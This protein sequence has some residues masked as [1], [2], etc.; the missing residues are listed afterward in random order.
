MLHLAF[1]E[2]ALLADEMGLGKTIQAIAAC[3][4][5]HHLGKARRVL[6]VTPASLKAEWE[7]Q[8]RKFTGLPLRLVFGGRALRSQIYREPDAALF[9]IANYEQIVADSLDINARLR[10]D[11]VI[12]DEAQRIKNWSTKTAQAVKRLAS[13]YA[14]VLTGTPIENRIDE[15]HSIVDFLDPTILGP[16]FRFNASITNWTTG[17]SGG[18]QNLDKLRERVRSILI[19]R[20]KADVET[21]LPDRADRNHFVILTPAMRTNTRPSRRR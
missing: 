13:R 17:P 11:I 7:E 8:I 6:I 19:R 20:R 3:A 1:N 21:E 2:R 14:F 18:L 16:L 9:T 5:L 12:L 4:L 15:L 10:P